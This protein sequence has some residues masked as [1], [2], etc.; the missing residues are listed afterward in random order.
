M[1]GET[2]DCLFLRCFNRSVYQILYKY[3]GKTG[4]YQLHKVEIGYSCGSAY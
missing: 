3:G 1:R 2:G 4:G